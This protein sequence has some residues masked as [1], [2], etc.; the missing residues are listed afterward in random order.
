MNLKKYVW[1]VVFLLAAI[2]SGT[3]PLYPAA[4]LADQGRVVEIRE[5]QGK[6]LDPFDRPYDNSIK[7]PQKVDPKTYRLVIDGLAQKPASLTYAQILELKPI[8]RTVV[9]YC[10]E[11]W[12][13]RLLFRGVRLAD[14]F[15]KVKPGP[16]ARFATFYAVDGY[17][18]SLPLEFI[19]KNDL[20]LAS[21]VNGLV[22]DDRRGFPFWL[23]AQ[24]KLG[25]K[26]VKWVTRI[27]LVEE[28][29]PGYWE[30]RGYPDEALVPASRKEE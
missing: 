20:L 30:K 6:K 10:V 11:G 22:L 14:L 24:D 8:E 5:Y 1:S 17:S 12:S 26:W 9:M 19:K 28:S 27:E 16:K 15:K 18:S 3:F 13:E 25:Y 29:I 4:A 7:G 23:A 2:L 21:H